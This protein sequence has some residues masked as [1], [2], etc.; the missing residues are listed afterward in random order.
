VQHRILIRDALVSG[1]T[2]L[3][4]HTHNFFSSCISCGYLQMCMVYIFVDKR[5]YGLFGELHH[6]LV[7]NFNFSYALFLVSPELFVHPL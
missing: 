2:V 3:A 6:A 4:P 1:N 5:R 7:Y